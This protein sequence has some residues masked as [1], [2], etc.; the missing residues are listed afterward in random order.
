MSKTLDR[1]GSYYYTRWRELTPVGRRF[2]I[3]FTAGCC[4]GIM[5][6]YD[7]IGLPII[8]ALWFVA[9]IASIALLYRGALI[10]KLQNKSK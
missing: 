9:T 10:A 5:T 7:A 1:I 8:G 2:S 3:Y 4:G 6:L